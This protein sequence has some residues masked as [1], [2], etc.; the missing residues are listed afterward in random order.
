MQDKPTYYLFHTVQ[1]S[2]KSC[3]LQ[4]GFFTTV[5]IEQSH[6]WLL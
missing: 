5:Q 4:A 2:F 1:Q 6:R 3:L